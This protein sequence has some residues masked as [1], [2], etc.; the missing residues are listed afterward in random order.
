M[1]NAV[2]AALIVFNEERTIAR[3]LSSLCWVDEILIVDAESTDQT[4]SICK[5]F[6]SDL[7]KLSSGIKVRLLTRAWTGFKDQ[8]NFA[9][10]EAKNDW[11]FVLDA[12]ES[13]SA[14]LSEKILSL[15]DGREPLLYSA[16]KV[17]R[18]E[19]FI[20]KEIRYGIWNPSYQDRFFNRKGVQYVN[21]VHEYPKFLNSPGVIHEPIFHDPSLNV[22]RFL[23]K[24][25]SYTTIESQDRYQHG[26]RTNVF[27]LFFAFFAMF[28][29]NFFY[30]KAYRDG[31]SGF[32]IS[33][34]EGVSRVVRHIKIWEL[35]E[36]NKKGNHESSCSHR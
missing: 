15:L 2:T 3:A 27:R 32:I 33:L 36:L 11:V 29:K 10:Q 14:E 7:N 6:E 9:L 24:M 16:Y 8:R 17:K 1:S 21:E 26:M 23:K 4:Y 13:C 12:D 20:G 18:V 31:M 28:F 35:T 22:S 30:Y 25:N 5:S 34:L 19:Y